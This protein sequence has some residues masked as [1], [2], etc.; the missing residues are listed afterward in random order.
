VHIVLPVPFHILAFGSL[1]EPLAHAIQ[2]N[3]HCPDSLLALLQVAFMA[4]FFETMIMLSQRNLIPEGWSELRKPDNHAS[5]WTNTDHVTGFLTCSCL[6]CDTKMDFIF[7]VV[8]TPQLVES[9]GL[10]EL[11]GGDQKNKT[12]DPD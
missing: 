1:R 5:S 7:Y 4:L 8:S 6:L 9:L 11:G 10:N 3:S 2:R 12:T